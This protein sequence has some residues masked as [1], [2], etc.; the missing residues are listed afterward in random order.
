MKGRNGGGSAFTVSE[1]LM[2][3]LDAHYLRSCIDDIDIATDAADKSYVYSSVRLARLSIWN[4]SEETRW[5]T[6]FCRR[7]CWTVYRRTRS[8]L[9]AA[10]CVGGVD[11]E[12]KTR[13]RHS[14]QYFTLPLLSP[15]DVTTDWTVHRF[16]PSDDQS[17]SGRHATERS[18]LRQDFSTIST[19]AQGESEHYRYSHPK[20]EGYDQSTHYLSSISFQS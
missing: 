4:R 14:R 17:G 10:R 16:E 12:G 3:S 6:A 15:S 8:G 7:R 2:V 18:I 11:W 5:W 20:R 9:C 1:I 13:S 19:V